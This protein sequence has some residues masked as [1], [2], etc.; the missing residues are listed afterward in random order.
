VRGEV[1]FEELSSG[2]TRVSYRIEGLTPGYH[3]FHVHE[4]ADFSRGCASAGAHFNPFG[5]AHGGRLSAER[6]V[7]D[8][9]NVLASAGGSAEGSFEDRRVAL[10]GRCSVVGRSIVVHADRDDEGCGGHDLSL[11]TGNAGARVAC[12]EIIPAPPTG[13]RL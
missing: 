2:E 6:H 9:G 8:L 3:G 13:G 10:R 12:G 4:T 11:T 1:L 5:M 7:G